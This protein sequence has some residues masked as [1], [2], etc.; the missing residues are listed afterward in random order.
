M[1]TSN[2]LACEAYNYRGDI[3]REE[4]ESRARAQVERG[5]LFSLPVR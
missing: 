1:E 2:L 5:T 4:S 3:N